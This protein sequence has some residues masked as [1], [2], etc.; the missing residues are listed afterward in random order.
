M[1][2]KLYTPIYFGYLPNIFQAPRVAAP[3]APTPTSRRWARWAHWAAGCCCDDLA[4]AGFTAVI[5]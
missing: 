4:T 5:L 2:Y 3:P 1:I